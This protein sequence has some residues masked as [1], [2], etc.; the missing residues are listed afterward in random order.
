VNAGLNYLHDTT[1]EESVGA[2]F[3]QDTFDASLS[4]RYLVTRRFSLNATYNFTTVATS[5]GFSDYY[6][7]ASS[8]EQ[9]TRFELGPRIFFGIRPLRLA[10]SV[11]Y[12]QLRS[13]YQLLMNDTSEVKLHFL[14]YWRVIKLRVGLIALAFLLIMITA[15]CDDLFP[16]AQYLSKVTMEVKPDN[17][18]THQ[19][20]L[21]GA[22]VVV[23]SILSCPDAVSRSSRKTKSSTQS[24]RNSKLQEVWS[25]GRTT[26]LPLQNVYRSCWG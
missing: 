4:A 5:A 8:W 26:P 18:G 14:D 9:S 1:T 24:S 11:Y 19:R 21:S 22:A 2:E 20:H 10:D 13:P 17:S 15:G 12:Y 6:G 16:P 3:T 23:V 25:K 7:T